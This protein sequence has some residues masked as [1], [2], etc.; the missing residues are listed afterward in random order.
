[1]LVSNL[2]YFFGGTTHQRDIK[3]VSMITYDEGAFVSVKHADKTRS[4]KYL[5]FEQIETLPD[6]KD[7][8]LLDLEP[9]G[10]IVSFTNKAG[11]LITGKCQSATAFEYEIVSN[12]KSS[13]YPIGTFYYTKVVTIQQ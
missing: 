3:V 11:N 10:K 7:Y 13:G 1:M 4:L 12:V 5:T 6:V 9:V 2:D 8:P